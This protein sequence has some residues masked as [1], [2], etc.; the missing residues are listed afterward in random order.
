MARAD[1]FSW[2][3]GGFDRCGSAANSEFFRG[4]IF[5]EKCVRTNSRILHQKIK[6]ALVAATY[7][8]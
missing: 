5:L 3:F 2:L 1:C 8:F 4:G 7:F 6:A